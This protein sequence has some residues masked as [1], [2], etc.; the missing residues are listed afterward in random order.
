MS[1]PSALMAQPQVISTTPS[2][3][4]TG[5]SLTTTIDVVTNAKLLQSHIT[6]RIPCKDSNYLYAR[7]CIYVTTEK[8]YDIVNGDPELLM[9]FGFSGT[10]SLLNDSTIRL[11]L[12][13]HQLL[14]EN[15][16]KVKI[17][18]L[19]ALVPNQNGFDTV[20]VQEY[21]FSFTTVEHPHKIVATSLQNM[22]VGKN[23]TLKVT[24]N[25]ALSSTTTEQGPLA[26]IRRQIGSFTDSTMSI[27]YQYDTITTNLSLSSDSKTLNILP[28]DLGPDT[29]Y[30]LDVNVGYLTGNSFNDRHYD[31]Y[32][33]NRSTVW[34]RYASIDSVKPI[35]TQLEEQ[36]YDKVYL[37]G[38]TILVKVPRV[39][40]D[41]YFIGWDCPDDMSIESSTL[42]HI[43]RQ[44]SYSNLKDFHITAK[45][46][47]MKK[48]TFQISNY[49]PTGGKIIVENYA[50][51]LG[52]GTYTVYRSPAA[53]MTIRAV[54]DSGKYF[55]NWTS[56]DYIAANGFESP[57]LPAAPSASYAIAGRKYNIG[58][59]G[60]VDI[61]PGGGV[62]GP[63]GAC[64]PT[65]TIMV[66]GGLS[67]TYFGLSA[68]GDKI[69]GRKDIGFD[70]MA[71]S[72]YPVVS[73]S[74]GQ[75]DYSYQE[76][77][78]TRTYK[79][80]RGGQD[81]DEQFSITVAPGYVIQH[82]TTKGYIYLSN[83]S[84]Y[85]LH[86]KG[87]TYTYRL[88]ANSNDCKP[89]IE[90]YL[91]KAAHVLTVEKR[92]KEGAIF[93]K[94]DGEVELITTEND[95]LRRYFLAPDE[96]EYQAE[97]APGTFATSLKSVERYI[98]DHGT[99]VSLQPKTHASMIRP[100]NWVTGPSYFSANASNFRVNDLVIDEPKQGVFQWES[101]FGLIGIELE[102]IDLSDLTKPNKTTYYS[103]GEKGVTDTKISQYQIVKDGEKIWVKLIFNYPVEISSILGNIKFS[104]LDLRMDGTKKEYEYYDENNFGVINDYT[105]LFPLTASDENQFRQL[106]AMKFNAHYKNGIHVKGV[107]S[108]TIKN[109][110]RT[111]LATALPKV[112]VELRSF[113]LNEV[114]DS[115]WWNLWSGLTYDAD[116]QLVTSSSMIK[117]GN[118][119]KATNS[120][121]T[122]PLEKKFSLDTEEWK[123][124]QHDLD[125]YTPH[126]TADMLRLE[127]SA[128][129][130][131]AGIDL[132][133][134]LPRLADSLRSSFFKT[135]RKETTNETE[136]NL[137]GVVVKNK[138]VITE[139]YRAINYEVLAAY[140]LAE[141][142]NIGLGWL[143]D[144]DQYMGGTRNIW[145]FEA[146]DNGYRFWGGNK[147]VLG[148][149]SANYNRTAFYTDHIAHSSI[150][151]VKY[152]V[153]LLMR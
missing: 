30:V 118:D 6:D 62:G 39:I 48:D 108:K 45:Y 98:F 147:P 22:Y 2:H 120:E 138:E 123:D 131:D 142:L 32:L 37:V 77:F 18:H 71:Q 33:L 81:I 13:D 95:L 119:R 29:A 94:G 96:E 124:I 144:R 102:T 126:T 51:S 23:D 60:F 67:H 100:H 90:I 135:V 59:G 137:D 4:A 42:P 78:Q 115:D 104:D 136:A 140:F 86:N 76:Y 93:R 41:M 117:F 87:T 9:M 24:F 148:D 73:V 139:S 66:K 70:P 110:G 106:N 61:N 101:D 153:T 72:S 7:P 26:L 89:T 83:T 112:K 15:L 17:A 99:V 57:S 85:Y 25:R 55:T 36:K 14:N 107:P 79:F 8:M 122:D 16:Y 68:S 88:I 27:T 50:D 109:P 58:H 114:M 103:V 10:I 5:V 43:Y 121:V 130:N 74:H 133:N 54:A 127:W 105:L 65:Y 128:V 84:Q 152:R 125:I 91:R 47:E 3:Q 28:V 82:I 145:S 111:V 64:I 80:D 146:D 40:K 21:D 35:P 53:S 150:F 63:T 97:V 1:R 12:H 46:A 132:N 75:G 129:D 20:D 113:L 34:L 31:F 92:G 151:D 116:V 141:F 11:T 44:L 38:D 49:N 56:S 134:F 143:E 149:F 52:N 19:K 69:Y